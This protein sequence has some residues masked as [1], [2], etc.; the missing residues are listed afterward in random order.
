[1]IQPSLPE[2]FDDLGEAAQSF[3]KELHRRRLVH[4]YYLKSTEGFNEVHHAALADPM[5]VLRRRLFE[6]A[7]NLWEGETIALK[8]DLI[9]ATKSWETLTEGG[10][11]CPIVFD[12]DDV[13][14]TMELDAALRDA[15]NSIQGAQNIIGSGSEGWV[16]R[17]HYEGAMARTKKLKE[18]ILAAAMSV[19]ERAEI[20]A[21]W[22]FDD[23]DE[24]KYM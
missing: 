22:P 12:D 9:E 8:V 13:R 4:Y 24:E 15:D 7:G 6:H 16:P 3:A 18:D 21:H 20:E 14:K 19:E 11:P 17:D 2:N 5:D 23:M 10:A 1:M